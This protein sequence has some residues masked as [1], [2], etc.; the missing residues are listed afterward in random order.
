MITG[1]I[2]A[3]VTIL[4][5]P[6]GFAH[7]QTSTPRT[8]VDLNDISKQ[9]VVAGYIEWAWLID[10]KT[11]LRAKLDT[12]AKSSSL[13]AVNIV[14]FMREGKPWVR[15]AVNNNI[16]SQST[17]VRPV[18]RIARIRRAGAAI[19]E[20]VVISLTICVSGKIKKADVTLANRKGMNYA[21]LIGR[22]F[23]R[24][25]ILVDSGTTFLGTGMCQ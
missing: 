21:L 5:L 22:S 8:A 17:F 2:L 9:Q 11:V 13:H 19:S 10:Y 14:R 7:A 25:Q 4:V 15:F 12:G 3:L 16:G 24:S 23:L 1:R 20:R 6:I 18:V